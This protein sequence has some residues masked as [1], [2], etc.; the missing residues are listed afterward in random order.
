MDTDL[1]GR[2]RVGIDIVSVSR[3]Q[4]RM[5]TDPK[6]YASR[7]LT[8]TE[9]GHCTKTAGSLDPQKVAGRI[10][11]KEAVMK[12]L[13]DGWPRVSWTDI[14]V[15]PGVKRRPSVR[16]TGNAYAISVSMCLSAVDISIS[17]DGGFAIAVAV[18]VCDRKVESCFS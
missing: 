8:E 6:R 10:A 12:V 16:L 1:Q 17:H 4:G 9:L 3:V 15:L 13:G 2:L 7:F 11:A 14:E 5:E 18:G